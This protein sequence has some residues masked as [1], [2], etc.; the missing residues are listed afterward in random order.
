MKRGERERLPKRRLGYTYELVIAGT[1]GR[2]KAFVTL[3][4]YPDGRLGEIFLSTA[5][6]GSALKTAHGVWAIGASKALQGGVCPEE[7]FRSFRGVREFPG[8]LECEDVPEIHG[9]EV[10]SMWDVIARLVEAEVE[11]GCLKDFITTAT[12][13]EEQ[14]VSE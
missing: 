7:Y 2:R 13:P 14:D 6:D 9:A 1:E 11:N 5:K 8:I 3:N 4:V 10:G 12:D